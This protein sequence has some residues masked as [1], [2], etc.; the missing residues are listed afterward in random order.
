MSDVEKK[1]ASYVCVVT[2]EQVLQLEN[3]L[4][5]RGW[6]FSDLPY[7]Y[8][9]A[10][11]EKTH[12]AAYRSGKLTVQGGGTA[13]FVSG[14]CEIV[15]AEGLNIHWDF[16]EGLGGVGMEAS[17]GGVD[18]LGEVGD[19]LDGAELVIGQHDGNELIR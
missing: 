10:S 3:L 4:R 12:V 14:D 6:T 2:P 8:W 1:C 9:K 15:H 17:A 5:D 11:K 18:G 16:T 13:D 19:G 7:G